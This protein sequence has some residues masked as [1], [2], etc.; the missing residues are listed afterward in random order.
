MNKLRAAVSGRMQSAVPNGLQFY[1]G[2]LFDRVGD[3]DLVVI[4]LAFFSDDGAVK[5]LV[6]Y[7]YGKVKPED[8]LF[9]A[10]A[11]LLWA[12]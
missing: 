9:L 4:P 5:F 1:S 7:R 2:S 6:E 12:R 11:V 10:I 8:L 3:D